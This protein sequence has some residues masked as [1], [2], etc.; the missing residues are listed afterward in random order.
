MWGTK[1]YS[2]QLANVH[3]WIGTLGIIVYALPMYVA[4]IVQGLMWKEFSP[5]GTLVYQNFLETVEAIKPMYL[6][7]AIG[8]SLYIV[9][10]FIMTYNLI[11]TMGSGSFIPDEQSEAPALEKKKI[12][13]AWHRVLESKPALFT[14]L[15]VVAILI[16]GILELVPTF[17]IQSNVPTIASV[18]PYTPLELH[19]RDIYIREGC[20]NCHSQMIRPFRSETARYRGEYSKAG[21][22]VYDHPFLWGSK[23]TGPDLHREGQ[24]NPSAQWHYKHMWDPTSDSPGS[25][26]PRYTWL[27]ENKIDKSMTPKIINAMRTVGVPYEDGFEEVANTVLE[28]QADEIVN[29]LKANG[30]EVDRELEI[31]ALISY[32]KR[33]GTDIGATE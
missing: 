21:E 23:R 31:I 33:L 9:G 32:L 18:K 13:G 17:L 5:E 10:A 29:E 24:T 6:T 20:Y 7:R 4:G 22:F 16:G 1:L 3:F 14:V 25:I 2:T 11:K 15:T 26:M 27:F 30:F 28:N 19:G 12:T 8:G